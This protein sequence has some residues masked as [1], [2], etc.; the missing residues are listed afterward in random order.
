MGPAQITAQ[1]TAVLEPQVGRLY[2]VLA[3]KPVTDDLERGRLTLKG[4]VEGV[5]LCAVTVVAGWWL[6][7]IR[8]SLSFFGDLSICIVG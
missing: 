6:D 5:F 1:P 4:E 3:T 2:G 7:F 8:Q